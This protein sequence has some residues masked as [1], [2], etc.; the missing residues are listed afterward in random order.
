MSDRVGFFEE[1]PGVRSSTRLYAF[2]IVLGILGI[3]GTVCFVAI[4]QPSPGATIA[5]LTAPLTPMLGGLWA[6]LR[7]R[8]VV[9]TT[10]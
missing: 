8:S 9:N 2:F 1:A 4:K 7:E 10:R 3:I 5:A 6:A